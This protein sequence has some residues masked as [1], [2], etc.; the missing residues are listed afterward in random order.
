VRSITAVAD[1]MKGA[2]LNAGRFGASLGARRLR[3]ASGR[4]E[5]VFEGELLTGAE[6]HL[7][8]R[9]RYVRIQVEDA[10][11]HRAWTNPLFIARA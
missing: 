3:S 5:G 8:G 10:S 9:E 4:P 6:L 11:G 7:T 2:R 1:G